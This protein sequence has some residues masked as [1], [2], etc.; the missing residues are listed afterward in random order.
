MATTADGVA[1]RAGRRAASSSTPAL[2]TRGLTKRFGRHLAIDQVDLRVEP[3]QIFGYLGPN[4][5]GKTTTIRLLAGLLRPTAG[6]AEV[7]G[8]DVVR[9]RD[10]MQSRIGYLP[11]D[12]R[13]YPGESA[14]EYLR[15]LAGLRGGVDWAVVESLSR[16]LDLDLGRRIGTM[17]HGNRQKVGIVQ[18]LMQRPGL[19]LLDEPSSGL[20]PLI[21]REFLEILREVR[22]AGQTVF[23]SSHVLSEVE[24][25]ADTVAILRQG[26]LVDV[27]AVDRLKARARRRMELT[28]TTTP[29]ASELATV[30]GVT[31]LEVS[32]RI[33]RLAI[34]GSTANLLAVAAPFQIERIVT[35]EPDLEEIFLGYYQRGDA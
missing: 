28:F 14:T 7:M 26:R 3:G 25:V 5:A 18:A 16:R 12:F 17:S 6:T 27:A 24:A 11:G 30:S 13:A 2:E 31:E 21:H 19:V 22:D 4:G 35:H 1:L 33:A 23:L 9:R 15:L 10:Q 34:E 8:F 32:G 29:P 20:D